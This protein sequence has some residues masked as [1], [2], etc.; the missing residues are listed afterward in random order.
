AIFIPLPNAIDDHQTANAKYLSEAGAAILLKQSD[1][2]AETLAQQ[3][4]TLCKN[5]PER[6]VIAQTLAY[7]NATD[8]VAKF[9]IAEAKA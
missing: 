5:L 2:T 8:T 1:L 7:L 4:K 3:I 9:C 6:R